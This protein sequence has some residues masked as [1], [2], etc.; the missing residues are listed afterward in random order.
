MERK[1]EGTQ[2]PQEGELWPGRP[3][4]SG[5]VRSLSCGLGLALDL[6]PI[7]RSG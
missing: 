3:H 4:T 7:K 1:E 6:F 2:N 5:P